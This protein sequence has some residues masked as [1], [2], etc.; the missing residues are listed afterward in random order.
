[1]SINS[2]FDA[3]PFFTYYSV[4]LEPFR[5]SPLRGVLG[6]VLVR[7]L[8]PPAKFGLAL[9]AKETHSGAFTK[10]AIP[11]GVQRAQYRWLFIL[12]GLSKSMAAVA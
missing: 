9:R 1:M 10:S 4:E 3:Q 6:W 7:G 8:T 11:V 2:R 5:N 12:R